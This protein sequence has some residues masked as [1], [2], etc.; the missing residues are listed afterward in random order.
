VCTPIQGPRTR[1]WRLG[2]LCAGFV[3]LLL[4]ASCGESISPAVFE[5]RVPGSNRTLYIAGSMHTGMPGY[6][7]VN[8]AVLKLL[9]ASSALAIEASP[10][11]VNPFHGSAEDWRNAPPPYRIDDLLRQ[12]R[13]GCVKRL[14]PEVIRMQGP[15]VSSMHAVW[16]FFSL[17]EGLERLAGRDAKRSGLDAEFASAAR[18][19]RIPVIEIEG[20]ELLREALLGIP[21]KSVWKSI[22]NMCPLLLDEAARASHSRLFNEEVRLVLQGGDV[23]R[24]AQLQR[25][26]WLDVQ[27]VSPDLYDT[28]I[29]YR[30]KRFVAKV[31]QL[32]ARYD[33]LF[34]AVGCG[35]LGGP[36]GMLSL[37]RNEGYVISRLSL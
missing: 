22:E 13:N 11:A 1:W 12:T 33:R 36:D 14:I 23:G 8:S 20:L 21:I 7:S 24:Q 18:F 35:H 32:G 30:S 25:H 34:I 16:L 3:S 2:A 27:G 37:L 28:V 17:E 19:K 26:R 5:A 31:K 9:E 29:A 10:Y 4:T 15:E 6:S